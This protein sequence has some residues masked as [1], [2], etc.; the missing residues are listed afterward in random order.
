MDTLFEAFTQADIST[1][2]RFGGTG[3]GLAI[4]HRLSEL[5]GGTL[6]VESTE[7]TG[8]TFTLALVV[9][10]PEQQ[11][12]LHLRDDWTPFTGRHAVMLGPETGTCRAAK[13]HV[14]AWGMT[15][16]GVP[17]HRLHDAADLADVL[18]LA[19]ADV[20]IAHAASLP[21]SLVKRVLALTQSRNVPFVPIQTP[22]RLSDTLR[23]AE[24]LRVPLR[25][26]QLHNTLVT[27]FNTDVPT[28]QV[29]RSDSGWRLHMHAGQADMGV[30]HPL[31]IIVAEDNLVNQRV[32]ERMLSRLGYRCDVVANGK[33]ACRA[34]QQRTYDLV[35]MDVHMPEMDG[36]DAT[37][38]IRAN[39]DAP[40]RIVALTAGASEEARRRCLDAGMDDYVPKPVRIGDLVPVLRAAANVPTPS[41]SSSTADANASA[42]P[43]DASAPPVFDRAVLVERLADFG[44][45]TTDD[46][47][48]QDLLTQ[49]IDDAQDSVAVIQDAVAQDAL[50][51]AGK[52]AHR[53]KS[54]SAT[55]GA[56]A[57]SDGCRTIEQAAHADNAETVR[58]EAAA[59]PD[60]LARTL[61]Q[62]RPLID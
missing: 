3:L 18:P 9:A 7:G 33:E 40:P 32:I 1:T 2:R 12:P 37:R 51:E 8:S 48:V 13:A 11:R 24:T 22:D 27:L 46:P 47:F 59:L 26:S 58:A 52:R 34:V 35:L 56:M 29:K 10:S 44:I 38:T 45:E 25:P 54:S 5:M 23:T 61:K 4:S 49:F 6:A 55:L 15:T 43:E 20:L 53:L 39:V 19:T 57:L 30:T 16:E 41:A 50:A 21:A 17:S 31:R 14:E 62:M 42:P 36:L 60:L 28:R